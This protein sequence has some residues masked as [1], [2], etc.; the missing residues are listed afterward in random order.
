[1]KI[2]LALLHHPVLGKQGETITTSVTNLDIH[3]I[4][5]SCRSYGVERYFIVT[6][7]RA[8]HQLLDK[9]LGHWKRGDN[10]AYNPDRASAL[11]LACWRHSWEEVRDEIAQRE[12]RAPLIAVTGAALHPNDGSHQKLRERL[13]VDNSPLLILFGTGHGL[14]GSVTQAA[15]FRLVPL[16]GLAE[17]GHNH[18]SVRSAVAIYLDRLAHWE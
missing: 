6:P 1:M 11:N 8:Q 2:Y 3:D 18:L 12:G 17:D 13:S 14:A 16:E 9:I 10:I 7:V 4:A 15:D 5:R